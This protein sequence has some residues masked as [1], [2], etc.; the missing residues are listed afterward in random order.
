MYLT[1]IDKKTGFLLIGDNEDGIMAIKE[2][3]DVLENSILGIKCLTAI[4]LTADYQSPIKFYS[5]ADRP[6]KAMEETTGSR[7]K[8]E[9]NLDVIQ[10]ALKKYDDLQ[11]DPALEEGRIHYQRK[12]NKLKDYKF[13]EANFGKQLKQKNGDLMIIKSP[14]TVSKELREIN[15]DIA[16][17][18]KKHSG[19]RPL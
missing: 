11:Y 9:W 16:E 5:D 8:F 3:R 12:V 6:K 18:E 2:F 15:S 19:E 7:N 1:R 4:A 13:S 17:Y 14:S 10:V